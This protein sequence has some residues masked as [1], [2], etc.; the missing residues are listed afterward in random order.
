MNKLTQVKLASLVFDYDLYPRRVINDDQ[1]TTLC[2][3]LRA[4]VALPPPTVDSKSNRVVDGWHRCRAHERINGHDAEITVELRQYPDDA[5]MLEEAVRLN[6][7]HGRILAPADRAHCAILAERHKLPLERLA[8]ALSVTPGRLGDL[9]R[10]K[11][12]LGPDGEAIALKRTL[13]HMRET[14]LTPA[15]IQVNKH[16]GG[17]AQMFYVN[18]L[19]A[20]I[21]ND[22]VDDANNLLVQQLKRLNNILDGY[23]TTLATTVVAN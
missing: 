18:Q 8:K 20:L 16:A 2:D 13:H 14:P 7:T 5:T 6:A 12:G 4:G 9:M 17:M 10:A 1:V 23:L 11:I 19:I 21:E 22:L 3:A 15:Q